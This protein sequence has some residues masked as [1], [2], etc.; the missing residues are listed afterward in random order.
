MVGVNVDEGTS[1]MQGSTKPTTT[2]QPEFTTSELSYADKL[3]LKKNRRST[4]P[5]LTSSPSALTSSSS[6][7]T[8]PGDQVISGNAGQ[9]FIAQNLSFF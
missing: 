2:Y 9:V 6:L 8:K 7:G 4:V 5:S 1:T 3:L